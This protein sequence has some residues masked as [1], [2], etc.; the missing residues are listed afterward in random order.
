MWRSSGGNCGFLTNN[1]WNNR[2]MV[3]HD[4][5]L[6]CWLY[7]VWRLSGGN[8]GC[9]IINC[10]NNIVMVGHDGQLLYWLY[11][12]WRLSGFLLQKV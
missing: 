9:L 6:L 1:S 12:V 4:G 3:G 10:C 5:L 8:F 7:G 11:G 2:V